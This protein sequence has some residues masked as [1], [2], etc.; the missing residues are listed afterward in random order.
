MYYSI[1]IIWIFI[2]VKSILK[3]N[4]AYLKKKEK[5]LRSALHIRYSIAIPRFIS[6]T[7]T[8]QS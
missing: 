7:N 6:R 5:R 4:A 2:H 3:G 1:T 8:A